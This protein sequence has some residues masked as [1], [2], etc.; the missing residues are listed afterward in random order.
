MA[1][2]LKRHASKPLEVYHAVLRYYDFLMSHRSEDLSDA[3]TALEKATT[4]DPQCAQAWTMRARLLAYVY[5]LGIPGYDSPLD[6]AF[7]FARNG[8]RLSPDDQRAHT[9]MAYVYLFGNEREAGL[10]EVE[11]AL[12]LGP[13][14]LFMLD[15]LGYLMTLLGN[16]EQGPALID[17]A[18]RSNPFYKNDVH[19]ALWVDWL[20][21]GDYARA[22]Q[23]TLKLNRPA[24]FWDH[25]ARASTLGLLGD[26]EGGCRSA[27]QLLRRRP[28]F[29]ADG[30]ILIQHFIKFEGIVDQIIEGLAAVDIA[31]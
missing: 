21:Q 20:R 29:H 3:L 7:E 4:I 18:I 28:D 8:I 6:K 27:A 24:L 10:A 16:W 17:K 26:I 5:A 14:S 30:R 25:L 11:K 2:G 9:V 12:A 22:G 1:S 31:I 15:V 19:Y 13:R 23:E